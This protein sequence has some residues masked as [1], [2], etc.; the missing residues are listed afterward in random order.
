MLEPP[1]LGIVLTNTIIRV[2]FA[3]CIH[4]DPGSITI[5]DVQAS[6]VHFLNDRRNHVCRRI[7]HVPPVIGLG[8]AATWYI[9]VSSVHF[10]TRVQTLKGNT[11]A[12]QDL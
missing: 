4:V 10:A 3:V 6:C 11:E 9:M 12:M 7:N 1:F 5:P 8:S 2:V